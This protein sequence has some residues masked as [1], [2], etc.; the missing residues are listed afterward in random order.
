MSQFNKKL[1]KAQSRQ[2]RI[3]F[4][5][6][7]VVTS[8]FLLVAVLLIYSRGTRVEV[9]PLEAGNLATISTIDNFSFNAG[10]VVYSLAGNPVINVSSPGF[11]DA[12]ETI[13]SIYL[14]KNFPLE[15]SELPGHLV[16]NILGDKN[17][18]LKT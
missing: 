7:L 15:L 9:M 16:I 3:Y 2:K 8:I 10:N 12:T 6:G 4:F 13:G 17:N 14:G 11:K 1:D 18:L 5:S